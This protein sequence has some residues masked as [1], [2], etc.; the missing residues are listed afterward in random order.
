MCA[1]IEATNLICSSVAK[2]TYVACDY[3]YMYIYSIYQSVYIIL[4]FCTHTFIGYG[5][6][7]EASQLARDVELRND[8]HIELIND[9]HVESGNDECV[10]LGNDEQQT[11]P[12]DCPTNQG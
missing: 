7:I 12:N 10:E 11:F 9:E 6:P 3:K 8:E 5:Q 2:G 1:F 4:F